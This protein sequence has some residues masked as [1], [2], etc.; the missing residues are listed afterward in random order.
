MCGLSVWSLC[1]R[2]VL[3]GWLWMDLLAWVW[4]ALPL[5][6]L[7]GRFR[8]QWMRYLREPW[9]DTKDRTNTCVKAVYT[10]ACSMHAGWYGRTVS[11]HFWAAPLLTYRGFENSVSVGC[12]SCISLT[13]YCKVIIHQYLLNVAYSLAVHFSGAERNQLTLEINVKTRFCASA[14]AMRRYLA[15]CWTQFHHQTLNVD[16]FWDVRL[17][18]RISTKYSLLFAATV[19]MSYLP[20][21]PLTVKHILIDCTCFGA[22]RQRYLGVDTLK[23]LWKCWIS[24]CVAFIKGTNFY[25]HCL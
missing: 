14:T 18:S 4:S 2:V 7:N 20:C 8:D 13:N 24:K 22:A 1:S 25:Y 9:V 16:A 10:W 3:P 12:A 15:Y 23:E 21:S 5:W 11:D 6:N 19:E 17:A